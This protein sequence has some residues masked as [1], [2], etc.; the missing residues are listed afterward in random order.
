M[1]DIL[2]AIL[3]LLTGILGGFMGGLIGVGGGVIFIPILHYFLASY[4][5][6][7]YVL[8]KL[9]LANSLFAIVFTGSMV[10]YRQY[11]IGNFYPKEIIQTA[12]PGVISS[13]IMT[14][15]I[16]QGSWY[17][18]SAFNSLFCV[19][20]LPL[21]VNMFRKIQAE[22]KT[23]I[24]SF[25]KYNLVGMLTGVISSLSGLGG[26]II[27]VPALSDF[28]HTGIKK[29]SSISSGVIPLLALP[30]TIFYAFSK[31]PNESVSGMFGYLFLP[32]AIPL[33]IGSIVGSPIGVYA[34]HKLNSK[35]IR[36]IF[37][38]FVSVVLVKM[39][40]EIF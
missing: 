2:N 25:R 32:I 22:Q 13:L 34:S 23:E 36:I 21:L 27:M 12:I 14:Y 24:L 30:M 28:L 4:A 37:V 20:L 6:P 31:S 8:V 10:S 5:F 35:I 33:I 16:E 11:K 17:S 39:L 18:K 9:V 26:G 3:L 1:H 29:A 15:I 19:L 40:Y 7:E 38:C